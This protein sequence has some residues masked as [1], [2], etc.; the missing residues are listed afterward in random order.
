MEKVLKNYGGAILFYI[1][2][3]VGVIA[4]SNKLVENNPKNI[5][6]QYATVL[7]D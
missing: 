6:H 5:N 3:F 2:L 4:I 7:N 1:V